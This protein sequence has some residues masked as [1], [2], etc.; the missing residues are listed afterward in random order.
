MAAAA[1]AT[2]AGSSGSGGASGLALTTLQKRHPRV[3]FSPA[4]MNVAVPRLQQREMFG[5][6]ASSQTVVSALSRIN[7]P[8]ATYPGP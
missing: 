4:I 3:Q 8:T 7:A 1:S 6:A 5:H 2:R